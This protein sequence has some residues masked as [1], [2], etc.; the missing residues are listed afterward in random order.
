[1]SPSPTSCSLPG[2]YTNGFLQHQLILCWE[3][4]YSLSATHTHRPELWCKKKPK[5]TQNALSNSLNSCAKKCLCCH[6]TGFHF[7]SDGSQPVPTASS[8]PSMLG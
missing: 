5:P 7:E 1:M 4:F 6:R 3:V 2:S 8:F